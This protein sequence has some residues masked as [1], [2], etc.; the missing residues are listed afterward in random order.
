LM[1]ALIVIS[2]NKGTLWHQ[3]WQK[4]INVQARHANTINIYQPFIVFIEFHNQ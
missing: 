3:V 4:R 2:F 1:S